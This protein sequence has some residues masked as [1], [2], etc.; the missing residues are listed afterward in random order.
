MKN[1]KLYEEETE[2]MREHLKNLGAKLEKRKASF[3]QE[4]YNKLWKRLQ[5]IH[6]K[7]DEIDAMLYD[8]A[9]LTDK[10][11]EDVLGGVKF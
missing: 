9:V 6:R 5:G 10:P 3:K 7:L 8:E 1:Q 4:K 11:D 2:G